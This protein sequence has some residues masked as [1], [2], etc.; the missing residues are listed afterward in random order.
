M[1]FFSLNGNPLINLHRLLILKR[2]TRVKSSI[3]ANVL[4]AMGEAGSSVV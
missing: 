2:E 4:F 3:E 1:F